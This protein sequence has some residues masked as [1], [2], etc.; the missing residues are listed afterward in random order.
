MAENDPADSPAHKPDSRNHPRH[1]VRWHADVLLGDHI[2][3]EGYARE[4]SADGMTLFLDLNPEREHIRSVALRIHVPPLDDKH[5]QHIVE[6]EGRIVYTSHDAEEHMFRTGIHFT[7]FE[8]DS[9][10]EFL[11]SRLAE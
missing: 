8:R 1:N 9:D 4:I 10:K 5:P 3:C 6:V 7:H 2:A 11:I